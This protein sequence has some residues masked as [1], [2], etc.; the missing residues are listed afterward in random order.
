MK[1]FY[2]L[3]ILISCLI[4]SYNSELKAQSVPDSDGDGIN[5]LLDIDD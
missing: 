3:I 4:F 2:R 1:Q 5:N